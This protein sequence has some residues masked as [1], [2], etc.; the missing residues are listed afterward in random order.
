MDDAAIAAAASNPMVRAQFARQLES[1]AAMGFADEQK[2]IQALVAASGNV[3][4]A[5][6]RLFSDNQ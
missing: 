4:A 3:D 6:D 2:S 5:L 1:L